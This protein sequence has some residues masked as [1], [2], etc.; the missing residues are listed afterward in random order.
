MKDELPTIWQCEAH[1]LAKHAI[2]ENYLKAW[3]PILSRRPDRGHRLLYIDAFAGPGV[4]KGGEPGSPL[5][6]LRVARYHTHDFPVPVEMLFIEHD[7]ERF[8]SLVKQIGPEVEA[9]RKAGK[10]QEVIPL[11]GNCDVELNRLLDEHQRRG[12]TFGPALAFLDQFGY[13]DVSME[14]VARILS[15][16]RCEVFSYLDYRGMNR[17]ISD[18]TK[19]AAFDRAFGS[20]VWKECIDLSKGKRRPRLIELYEEALRTRGNAK[21]VQTFLMFDKNQQP[22]YWLVFCTNH[23]RGL[24]EM[25][26]A[27]WSVDG[28]GGFQFSD[29]DDSKQ[30]ALLDVAYGQEWLV[31]EICREFAGKRVSAAEVRDFVITRTPCH[32]FRKALGQIEREEKAKVVREPADRRATIFP[33]ADLAQIELQFEYGQLF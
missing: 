20:D 25:K 14:L 11:Q 2:L 4:Y 12:I 21:Y 26:G 6:A 30:L 16:P 29:G 10:V 28:K 3:L 18:P 15:I 22:L 8:A 9:A 23:I 13:G 33:E 27:M 19:A 1:T 17:W 24:E 5:I 32:T 31:D 7:S